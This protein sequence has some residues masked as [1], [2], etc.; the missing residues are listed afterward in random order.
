M[1]MADVPVTA[2]A[3]DLHKM[4]L[5]CRNRD[6]FDHRLMTITAR[7]L[8]HLPVT[9]G[10]LDRLVERVGSEIIRMPKAVRGLCVIFPDEI[11]R[12]VAIVAGRNGVM[13]RFL[14]AVVL[15]VH[16]VTIGAR[17]GVVAQ[18]GISLRIHERVHPDPRGQTDRDTDN[19][20]FY[21][22]DRHT[23]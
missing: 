19:D 20:E 2:Y 23:G 13:A 22:T 10:Y 5:V 9:L 14:P 6:R 16:Y 21:E 4:A 12:R 18:I 15:L 1:L 8:G 7:F 3:R 11:M 17:A